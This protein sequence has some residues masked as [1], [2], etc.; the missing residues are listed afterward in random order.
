MRLATAQLYKPRWSAAIHEEWTR[1]LLA[2]RP[3]LS[4]A[5]LERTQSQ[6]DGAIK[7]A[8][9]SGYESRINALT[10]PDP[11]DRHVLAAAIESG[12]TAIVTFNLKDFPAAATVPYGVVA[13]GPDDFVL[14][15]YHAAPKDFVETVRRH[16]ASL[17]RPPK[18]AAEYIATMKAAQLPM[19]AAALATHADE[20]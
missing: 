12:A 2:D 1:N 13:I 3:D 5:Q 11:N 16:R 17:Q 10:L 18:T 14:G 4:Q 8:M 19:T 9:V 20:I 15:L 7:E 6:M